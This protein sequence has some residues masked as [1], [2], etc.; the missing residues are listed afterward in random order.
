MCSEND[1]FKI[2]MKL[3]Q[4]GGSIRDKLINPA[5]IPKDID[6]AVEVATFT[7][8]KRILQERGYKIFL[9]KPEFLTV[10]AK[11]PKT[12]Q[13]YDYS[14]CR[15]DGVYSNARHPDSVQPC[16]IFTDLSR[17]DF[18][19]NAIAVDEGGNVLD[20]YSGKQDIETMTLRCVGV[21]KERLRED[22]LR[23][24]R[25]FRF[26]ITKGFTFDQELHRALHD[27][28]LYRLLESVSK[29]RKMEE[30]VKMMNTSETTIQTLR[31]LAEYPIE[32]SQA[33]FKDGLW[34]K[35][36]YEKPRRS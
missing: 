19:V 15:E 28:K 7:D 30:L 21:A 26:A 25:A 34:L 13:V 17:R 36:T 16:D 6:Y 14:M 10:R 5:A 9:E 22:S 20:P 1:V 35:A 2:V 32:L 27:P 12:N 8:M 23:I 24:L 3:Y 18:T 4:V 31:M 11:C 29:E 33:I